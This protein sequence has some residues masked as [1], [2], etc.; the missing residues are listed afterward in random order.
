MEGYGYELLKAITLLVFLGTQ[1]AARRLAA[2]GPSRP[3]PGHSLPPGRPQEGER[4][5]DEVRGAGGAD[6][7]AA[8]RRLSLL[9][10]GLAK[11]SMSEGT[12]AVTKYTS[13]K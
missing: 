6:P 10:S 4:A 2:G 11:N 3:S 5:A 7:R 1:P 8:D 12:N 13:S 9:P